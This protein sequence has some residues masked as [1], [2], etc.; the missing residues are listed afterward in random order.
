MPFIKKCPFLSFY[1]TQVSELQWIEESL[2]ASFCMHQL[3]IPLIWMKNTN[4]YAVNP[5]TCGT[6]LHCVCRRCFSVFIFILFTIFSFLLIGHWGGDARIKPFKLLFSASECSHFR[7]ENEE[8]RECV[9]S[10]SFFSSAL[11]CL[12]EMPNLLLSTW[13]AIGTFLLCCW[14][15]HWVQSQAG[16]P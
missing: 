8:R 10:V 14:I 9:T 15:S 3:F 1:N 6:N 16:R 13:L 7:W 2:C 12:L 5:A 11:N 4:K